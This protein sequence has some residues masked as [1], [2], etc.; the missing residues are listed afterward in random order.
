MHL[1][2]ATRTDPTLPLSRLRARGQLTELFKRTRTVPHCDQEI[3]HYVQNDSLTRQPAT[4][5]ENR[6]QYSTDKC[7]GR[8]DTRFRQEPIP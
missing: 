2:I 7:D 3:L 6:S 8:K 5:Q 1:V 4:C